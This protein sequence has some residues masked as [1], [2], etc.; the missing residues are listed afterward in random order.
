MKTNT[1][2]TAL[3]IRTFTVPVEWVEV[4]VNLDAE[5]AEYIN[6]QSAPSRR[7]SIES[8]SGFVTQIDLCSLYGKRTAAETVAAFSRKS[9]NHGAFLT[10][11]IR[12]IQ[13]RKMQPFTACMKLKDW[14]R[15]EKA[16]N[17]LETTPAAIVR[18]ALILRGSQ[19]KRFYRSQSAA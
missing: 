19:I 13:G 15:V 11:L 12:D 14:Q 9:D 6:S 4:T 16:A 17:F 3:G 18:G 8:I 5:L 7:C 10:A 1:K 2:N